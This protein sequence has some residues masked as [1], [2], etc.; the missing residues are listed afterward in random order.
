MAFLDPERGAGMKGWES[1]GVTQLAT[2]L[3]FGF[4]DVSRY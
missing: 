1:A 2:L 4:G 3:I